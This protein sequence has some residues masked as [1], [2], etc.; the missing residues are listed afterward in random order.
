[1]KERSAMKNFFCLSALALM[2]I[3]AAMQQPSPMPPLLEPTMSGLYFDICPHVSPAEW[4]AYCALTSSK[5]P[6][7]T[8]P[9]TDTADMLEK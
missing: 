3:S 9:T 5:A 2:G 6:T 4:A 7:S 1:M 8:V